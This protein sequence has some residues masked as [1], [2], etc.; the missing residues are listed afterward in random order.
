M[1]D[2]FRRLKYACYSTNVSMSI[3]SNL[4]P[5]LFLT[6]R[7]MYG[8]SYSLLGLLVLINFVTQ[9]SVDLVFSFFSHKFNIPKIVKATPALTAGGLIV[10]ALWPVFSPSSAYLG[11]VIGTVLFSAS[12]GFAEVLI[13]PVIAAIPSD[14]TERETSKLHSVYAWGVVF[15]I[16]FATLFLYFFGRENWSMMVLILTAIPL[17]AF[18]LYLGADIPKMAT[19]EK[20]S[21]VLTPMKDRALWMCV[22]LIFLGGAT[23]V[24][25]AQWSS[26][27]LEQALGIPKVLGDIFGVAFFS[28]MLGLG[29]TLYSK[30]GKS[31]EKILL[32]GVIGAALC[33]ASAA[34]INNAYL[35]IIICAVTGFC[36]SMLWPGS[37]IVAADKFPGSGVFIYAMMAAG[38]DLGASV[39]PQLIGIVTDAVA[40]SPFASALALDTGLSPE[41]LGMKAGMII[42]ALFP[43]AAVPLCIR[44][45]HKGTK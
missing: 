19:P 21:G 32:L 12:G 24:A 11:L 20:V 28:V 44:L 1:K 8:I 14:N 43:I 23:E 5:V 26:G 35:G 2:Q 7:E 17:I 25:M 29:R 40:A 6:F 10:Y 16:I 27:Y 31:V 22:T 34:F 39:S 15:I 9:L 13:T 4:S 30:F 41:Q 18:I 3:V 42:A 45:S 38:G 33:Y 36:V 37:L